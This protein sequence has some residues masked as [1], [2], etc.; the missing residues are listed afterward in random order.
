[1]RRST[2]P[3]DNPTS[4]TVHFR[5]NLD[6]R[7]IMEVEVTLKGGRYVAFD[8]RLAS[9][10]VTRASS[11]RTRSKSTVCRSP[12]ALDRE[13]HAPISPRTGG[14]FVGNWGAVLGC[15]ELWLSVSNRK[16]T[17]FDPNFPES[18]PDDAN[19]SESICIEYGLDKSRCYRSTTVDPSRT[20]VI[21][22]DYL[23]V[24]LYNNTDLA[25]PADRLS[26]FYTPG[27]PQSTPNLESPDGASGRSDFLLGLST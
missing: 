25:I 10:L 16:L 4:L 20:E 26:H 19:Q 23:C 9:H 6:T 22:L 14:T 27:R 3:P 2:A 21:I 24:Y 13:I 1:M 5:F 15:T 17:K 8:P 7:A 11:E 12:I 18:F